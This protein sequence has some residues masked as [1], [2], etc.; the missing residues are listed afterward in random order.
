MAQVSW[1]YNTLYLY[2]AI[3]SKIVFIFVFPCISLSIIFKLR[4]PNYMDNKMHSGGM[5]K[6]SQK[7]P[8][9]LLGPN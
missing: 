6:R 3:E 4:L 2:L 5:Q 1:R 7:S 9:M 8:T